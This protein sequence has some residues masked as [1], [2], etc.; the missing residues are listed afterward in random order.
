MPWRHNP[1]PAP[2]GERAAEIRLE[3]LAAERAAANA[4]TLRRLNYNR[5]CPGC[6]RRYQVG[7]ADGYVDI[8]RC[9][10]CR[11]KREEVL[12]RKRGRR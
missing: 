11:R 6:D 8:E 4:E 12:E 5:L 9:P 7:R 10:T 2:R 1:T 3:K